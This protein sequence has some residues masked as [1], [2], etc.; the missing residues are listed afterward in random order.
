MWTVFQPLSRLFLSGEGGGCADSLHA[1]TPGAA[2]VSAVL[3][4]HGKNKAGRTEEP[5]RQ[6]N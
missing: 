6:N 1:E 3:S 4:W 2:C 5:R